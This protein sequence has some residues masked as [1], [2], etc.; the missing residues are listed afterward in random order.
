MALLYTVGYE[1]REPSEIAD[2]LESNSVKTLVDI[3]ELPLSR[4][5]GFSKSAL[6]KYM[7]RRKVKYTHYRALGSPRALRHKVRETGDLV[8]FFRK[9]RGHLSTQDAALREVSKLLNHGSICLLCYEADHTRCHRRAVAG[10]V[11]RRA[12]VRTVHL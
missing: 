9:Y 10:R 11:A 5:K 12:K 6:G 4:R 3:R 2:L 7:K 1:G 8:T